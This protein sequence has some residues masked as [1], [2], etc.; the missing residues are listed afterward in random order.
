[1]KVQVYQEV[2]LLNES[3]WKLNT[4]WGT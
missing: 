3:R 4:M 1:M 2:G